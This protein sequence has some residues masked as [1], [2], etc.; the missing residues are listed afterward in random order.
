[1]STSRSLYGRWRCVTSMILLCNGLLGCG[2]ENQGLTSS[3][4]SSSSSSMINQ[5]QDRAPWIQWIDSPGL[6]AD[7]T[8]SGL[9][10]LRTFVG[11][12]TTGIEK[13]EFLI[14]GR[15]S[16]E[17][18][19]TAGA[20]QPG[21]PLFL[22]FSIWDTSSYS[23]GPHS[24]MARVTDRIGRT[25]DT[26]TLTAVVKNQITMAPMLSGATRDGIGRFSVNLATG[27]MTGEVS[28]AQ[29]GI[30]GVH[31]HDGYAGTAGEQLVELRQESPG[32]SR[33]VVPAD[34]VLTPDQ[35]DRL[36]RG[37]LYVDLDS[38]VFPDGEIRTQIK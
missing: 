14:D 25:A 2:E 8:A 11:W 18:G 16:A 30:V 21:V 17:L 37:A 4:S 31:I 23:D 26:P 28:S 24:V 33:W 27:E 7:G 12:T 6:S 29:P 9:V 10:S 34:T 32:S 5:P 13:V 3:G 15:V 19:E 22:F 36:L 20:K 1:M 35:T 38:T